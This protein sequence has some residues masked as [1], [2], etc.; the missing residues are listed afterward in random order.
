MQI[1]DLQQSTLRQI[2]T[3]IRERR[4]AP[5]EL[6]NVLLDQIRRTESKLKAYLTVCSEE[7]L[8]QAEVA[9]FQLRSGHDLGPL[10][11]IPVSVKDNFETQG[12]RT[13][14]GSKLLKNYVPTTDCTVVKHL[15][16]SGAIILGKTNTHEFALGVITPPTRN[17]W[18]TKRIP[19]GSSGGSA[20]AVAASSAVVATG[21]DTA[22]SIRIPSSF[23]GTV[24]LKPTYGRVSR[25][26]VIPE[27]WSLDHIG[28]IAK[29]VDDAAVLL[30]V[31]AGYD[32]LDP[33]SSN[34]AV[35][36]Y[37]KALEN[38]VVEL[39]IGVPRN[40][41]FDRCDE[42]VEKVVLGGVDLLTTLGCKVVEFDFP[43]VPEIFAACTAIDIC[44]SSAF[45]ERSLAERAEDFSPDVRS[46]LE[47]GL[48]VPAKYYINAL[49]TR[50]MI[51]TEILKLFKHFDVMITPTEPIV[52]PLVETI[53]VSFD[54][55]E[56]KATDAMVR[57]TYPFNLIGLPAL[58]I[59][60]GFSKD[61]MPIGMQIIGKPFAESTVLRLGNSYEQATPWH[62]MNP[63]LS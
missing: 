45:H 30:S 11:G 34:R 22:G 18:D 7:A 60:C 51:F 49:R 23:C 15:K 47:P 31:M 32:P 2:E 26:G 58:S 6:V 40:H 57:F 19:G 37:G 1:S 44:E 24:G 8:K 25:A 3:G 17:P 52:A 55:S 4:I 13:T 12:I 43:H 61:K 56:E 21:S 50:A 59:P 29:R 39:R 54:G 20:A 53:N 35:P 48:L 36:N 14:C 62:A 27:C 5:T 38:G 33:N 41:F 63:E 46:Y 16:Q 28:P 10:H 42:E 9:E